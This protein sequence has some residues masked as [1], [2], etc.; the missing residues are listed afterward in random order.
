[1]MPVN[2]GAE[3]EI[4]ALLSSLHQPPQPPQQLQPLQQSIYLFPYSSTDVPEYNQKTAVREANIRFPPETDPELVEGLKS[5][6][7]SISDSNI[8]HE[9]ITAEI[10]AL[11]L[12]KETASVRVQKEKMA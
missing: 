11:E 6:S 5:L 2:E 4:E 8:R 10:K 3:S 9:M 12:E 7:A 1:M